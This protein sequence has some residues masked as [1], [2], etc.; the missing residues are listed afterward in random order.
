[1]IGVHLIHFFALMK[2]N[3]EQKLHCF[4]YVFYDS[5]IGLKLRFPNFYLSSE[6]L[7][8]KT[9]TWST[10]WDLKLI[11]QLLNNTFVAGL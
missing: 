10:L 5:C 2:Y 6:L 8:H 1:M 11:F 3:E 9:F 7:T 4:V